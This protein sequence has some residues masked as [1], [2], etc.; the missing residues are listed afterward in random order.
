M[1]IERFAPDFWARYARQIT[2]EQRRALQAIIQCR[3]S[4]LGGHRYACDCGHEHYTFHSCNHRLCPRCGASDT[5]LWIQKQLGK[6][7]PVPYYMVTFTLPAQLRP[8][9]RGNRQ[10]MEALMQASAQ[11]LAE[12]IADP[13]RCGF[14]RNGFFGV[15]QS[16]TQDMRFHPHVHFVVPA[17]GLDPHWKIKRLKNPKFLIH[18]APLAKRL[19][20]LLTNALH[21]AGIIN[22]NLF[23][24]L[25]KIDWNASVDHAGSGENA[26]K[27]LGQYIRRSVIS[28]ARII[29][30]EKDDVIIRIKNRDTRAYESRRIKGVEFIRR[31][32]LHALPAH[33]HRI[34]YRGFLHA[35]GKTALQWLQLLLETRLRPTPETPP[36]PEHTHRCPRCGAHMQQT[37]RMPRAPPHQRNAHFLMIV[38]T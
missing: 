33:F 20:T 16:W 28:D 8:I 2:V 37:K 38:A 22:K 9:L 7:L 17:I 6:L 30:I 34:R 32:L 15:Y 35:R 36:C 27:Y 10:A 31:F 29:A 11:A 24:K 18:A 1:V 19:R 5:Q 25:L 3:T 12:L 21:D 14:H 26:V 4:A 23:W 13:A